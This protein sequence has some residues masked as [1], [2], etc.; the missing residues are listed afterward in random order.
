MKNIF[1]TQFCFVSH[2][3]K[4]CIVLY[5]IFHAIFSCHIVTGHSFMPYC[6]PH[7]VKA[8]YFTQP[9]CCHIVDILLPC[10]LAILLLAILLLAILLLAI[11]L[12]AILL[13]AILLL[14][15]LLLVI[16]LAWHDIV[17]CH[18]ATCHIVTCHI[19]ACHIGHI[20]TCKF[21]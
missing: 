14:A 6:F 4:F 7:S 8:Y 16:L 13:L 12:L 5:I 17:T 10:C 9:Y 11:L 3:Q 20:V 1:P 18:I 19:V 2:Q 21:R 15:I